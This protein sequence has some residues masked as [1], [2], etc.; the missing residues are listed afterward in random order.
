MFDPL[1]PE[2]SIAVVGG[3]RI[4]ASDIS[5]ITPYRLDVR[6]IDLP[7]ICRADREYAAAEMSAFL[8]AWFL[9]LR[10]E[11]TTNV[12]P[13]R[14]RS[15]VSR[16]TSQI[17]VW[18]ELWDESTAEV[19]RA[20]IRVGKNPRMIRHADLV[21][22][23]LLSTASDQAVVWPNGNQFPL[24][25]VSAVYARPESAAMQIE[26]ELLKWA[27][28]AN[29]VVIN[30]P[31]AALS[32]ASKPR[33]LREIRAAGMLVPPTLV[34]TDPDV[35]AA[36][37]T[38][39]PR[40]IFKSMSG[41]RSVVTACTRDTIESMGRVS[42]CPTMFQEYVEGVDVRCHIVGE[43]VFCAEVQS[44]AT[45]YRYGG[46]PPRIRSIKLSPDLAGALVELVRTMS[47]WIGGADLRMKSSGD[48]YCFEV[49]PSPA[50][51][52]YTYWTGQP[53][54]AAIA[55]LLSGSRGVDP[56]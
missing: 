12:V 16:R 53:I 55:E 48:W 4:T 14:E 20:L 36:Y 1:S 18:G 24:S 51:T 37:V 34:T 26:Y 22:A 32:N 10:D 7:W 9:A 41:V 29:A 3:T 5:D 15:R 43:D 49:N 21:N 23:R 11:S 6:S 42:N 44:D 46:E 2:G 52:Y 39:R 40:V 50:F 27:D 33:H 28:E 35:A 47:L 31:S 25:E 56:A 19:Y 13:A 8:V 17:V 54:A 45:D 38:S 30:R